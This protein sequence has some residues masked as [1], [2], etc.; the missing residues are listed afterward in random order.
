MKFLWALTALVGTVSATCETGQRRAVFAFNNEDA[1]MNNDLCYEDTI[2]AVSNSLQTGDYEL[3][4]RRKLLREQ[5][6]RKL[7]L[8]APWGNSM[9]ACVAACAGLGCYT[10]CA[11]CDPSLRRGLEVEQADGNRQL[12]K[13]KDAYTAGNEFNALETIEDSC[14]KDIGII[15]NGKFKEKVKEKTNGQ[16]TSNIDF[17]VQECIC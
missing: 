11:F 4:T 16:P 17:H 3:E 8:C 12:Q 5:K 6:D 1:C 2:A 14:W 9:S 15:K 7:G 13:L 10:F